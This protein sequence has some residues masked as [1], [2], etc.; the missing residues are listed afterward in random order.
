MM[1]WLDRAS[2]AAW[3]AEADPDDAADGATALPVTR[4]AEPAAE[5]CAQPDSSKAAPDIS[6]AHVSA[7]VRSGPR[8]PRARREVFMPLGRAR[9][10]WRFPRARAR[11]GNRL[12]GGA[13]L[14]G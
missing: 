10:P 6:P 11:S 12:P 5:P 4:P 8:N 7:V 3:E 9:R 14:R 2:W 13:G 1:L